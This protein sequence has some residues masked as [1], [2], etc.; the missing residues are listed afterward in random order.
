[1]IGELHSDEIEVVLGVKL[2][3]AVARSG[4]SWGDEAPSPLSAI[5]LRADGEQ[6]FPRYVET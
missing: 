1:M 4:R 3:R 5:A 6:N 2:G